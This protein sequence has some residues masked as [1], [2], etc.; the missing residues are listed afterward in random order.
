MQLKK[1]G[2]DLNKIML[3]T[4]GL[5]GIWGKVD[6]MESERTILRALEL[7]ISHFDSSPAYADAELILGR[8]LSQWKG[9]RPFI[10]TKAGKLKSDDPD[11]VAYD[12]SPDGLQRSVENSLRLLKTDQIDLLFLHDPT[13]LRPGEVEQAIKMFQQFKSTGLVKQ[14]GIGGNFGA[15]FRQFVC[16]ENFDFFMGY[17]R[18]NL[19]CRDAREDEFN[20]LST[21]GIRIC[22][23][24]PLYMG[25]LGR[26]LT[27]YTLSKPEWIPAEHLSKA[28]AFFAFCR[29]EN[30]ELPGLAL[31]F[32]LQS[33][34]L[35]KVVLGAI[36]MAELEKSISWLGDEN[37]RGYALNLLADTGL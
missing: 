26:K 11:S 21:Q 10:S 37:L 15:S 14:V 8:A 33:D 23:A 2:F 6:F 12:F 17:N 19:V 24:S 3:G 7:G 34:C 31:Q 32:L 25:L 28:N 1:D 22:Q 27:D 4:A 13:G 5:A 9:P 18:Y 35:N 16:R 29:K 20:L 30:I 36:N